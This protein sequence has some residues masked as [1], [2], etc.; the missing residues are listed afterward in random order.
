MA[1]LERR[2]PETSDRKCLAKQPCGDECELD[3]I[4]WCPG[5]PHH[6]RPPRWIREARAGR[7]AERLASDAG[8]ADDVGNG[9]WRLLETMPLHA[10]SATYGEAGLR[11]RFAAE[12]APLPGP[13]RR[14]LADALELASRLHRQD[15]R[16][17]EPY[18]NHPV[19]VAIQIMTDYGIHDPDVITAALLHDTVEDH[20]AGLAPEGTT[21]AA[22]GALADRFGP[23]VAGLVAAV[24]NPEYEPGRG[25]NEQYR[26]HVAASLDASPWAR[27]INASDFTDNGAGLTHTT[28]RRVA[29][30]ARKYAG[31]VPVLREL[32]SRT[33]TPL[34]EPA[35]R[36]IL[37][38]LDRAEE[39][40]AAILPPDQA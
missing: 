14:R 29:Y 22:V 2:C 5:M 36:R 32:I 27:V 35:R 19:R 28:G 18:I 25:K 37:E 33:D 31:V 15:W 7:E 17:N 26:E 4:N 12:I 34:S 23:R 3:G 1:P 8:P 20:A 11:E 9:R 39:R 13:D 38:Q 21:A 16:Q 30:L 40:F 6:G 10:I 24:T